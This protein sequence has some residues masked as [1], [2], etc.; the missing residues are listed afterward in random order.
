MAIQAPGPPS[1]WVEVL[2]DVTHC[3]HKGR[4]HHVEPRGN[5]LGG[6]LLQ[7]DLIGAGYHVAHAGLDRHLSSPHLA[8]K[9][10]V[11]HAH[12]L[13]R[14]DISLEAQDWRIVEAQ[15]GI[16]LVYGT[17]ELVVAKGAAA[18]HHG[19]AAVQGR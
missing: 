14:P 3:S 16:R 10:V 1:R 7:T 4:V 17:A 19:T 6:E 5:V 2:Q 15:H 8:N 12:G 13:M 9:L 11:A 18:A